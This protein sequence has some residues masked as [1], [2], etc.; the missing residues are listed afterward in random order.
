MELKANTGDRSAATNT[1]QSHLYGIE[2]MIT[3]RV[4]WF[5]EV[6]I[7]PLWNWKKF[8]VRWAGC[9]VPVSIAPLWN[10]KSRCGRS[11]AS[12]HPFQ[13]HL[14]GIESDVGLILHLCHFRFNRT[15]M[16]LKE[17]SNHFNLQHNLFQSHLYGIES[18]NFQFV[19]RVALVSIAP[20]WN[21]KNGWYVKPNDGYLFQSHLY[22]IESVVEEPPQRCEIVFQSHLYGIERT[23]HLEQCC[24]YLVSIAPLWNWKKMTP[25]TFFSSQSFNRTFMELKVRYPLMVRFSILFQSHLYGIE[26]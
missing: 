3:A 15:F 10:W 21:W 22:G 4:L 8:G 2:R 14:Y 7:A 25:F 24:R 1:F 18:D 6:S 5:V 16:E 9:R 13:S 17:I 23:K 19:K 11:R 26:S 12:H 20:L